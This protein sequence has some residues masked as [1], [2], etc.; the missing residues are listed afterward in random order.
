MIEQARG[1]IASSRG[2]GG[3]GDE[4]REPRRLHHLGALVRRSFSSLPYLLSLSEGLLFSG[5]VICIFPAQVK[6]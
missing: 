3:A 2:G 1:K 4:E 5:Y 6:T